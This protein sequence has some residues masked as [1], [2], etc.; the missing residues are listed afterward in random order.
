MNNNKSD[1]RYIKDGKQSDS[2]QTCTSSEEDAGR[3]H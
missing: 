3:G 2:G 1:K